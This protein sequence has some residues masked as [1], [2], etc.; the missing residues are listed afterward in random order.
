MYNH[1]KRS[2]GLGKMW[3]WPLKILKADLGEVLYQNGVD[4]Y[5]FVRCG[6]LRIAADLHVQSHDKSFRASHTNLSAV[7]SEKNY[8]SL[9]SYPI[10]LK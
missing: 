5:L 4:A 9:I 10:M 1:S 8:S 6:K 3:E 7:Q 2:E